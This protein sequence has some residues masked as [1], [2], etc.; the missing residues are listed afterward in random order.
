MPRVGAV[1][2]IN[3]L[4]VCRRTGDAEGE[5]IRSVVKYYHS[6]QEAAL[7]GEEAHVLET[8]PSMAVDVEQDGGQLRATAALS[9][10]KK[11]KKETVTR[12]GTC[13]DKLLSPAYLNP[14]LN[15]SRRLGRFWCD[16]MVGRECA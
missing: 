3:M 1:S 4:P 7:A 10:K 9:T 13:D 2:D 12:L 11:K 5:E 6:P 8:S 16:L 15:R 14:K